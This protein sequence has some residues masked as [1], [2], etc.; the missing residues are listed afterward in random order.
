MDEVDDLDDFDLP[1]AVAEVALDGLF[2]ALGLQKGAVED[3]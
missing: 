2:S 1:V 3:A